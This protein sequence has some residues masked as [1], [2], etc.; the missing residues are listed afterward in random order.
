MLEE[1]N[2]K[3]TS[4]KLKDFNTQE[5]LDLNNV[6]GD[7]QLPRPYENRSSK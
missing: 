6:I 2:S 5:K 4:D 7:I 3:Y 1:L